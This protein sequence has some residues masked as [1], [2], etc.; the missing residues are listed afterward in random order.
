M[1]TKY[2][3]HTP[4]IEELYALDQEARRLRAKAVSELFRKAAKAVRNA[5]PRN[6]P[7]LRPTPRTMNHA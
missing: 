7:A 1:T 3:Y 5:F 6:A 2:E 4:S